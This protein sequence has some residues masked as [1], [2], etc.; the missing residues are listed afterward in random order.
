M[1]VA[2]GV[3]L[4]ALIVAPAIASTTGRRDSYIL[5]DGD[6]TY[7]VGEGMSAA[8]LKQIQERFGRE[9]FWVRRNGRTF[10]SH[11]DHVIDQVRMVMQRNV[12]DRSEQERRLAA[13]ADRAFGRRSAIGNQKRSSGR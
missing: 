1:R 6:I 13:I 2:L 7:M 10:V 4:T 9:F 5:R 12:G 3:L 8:S 11:D